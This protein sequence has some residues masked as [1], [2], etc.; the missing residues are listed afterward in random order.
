M[1]LDLACLAGVRMNADVWQKTLRPAGHIV[2][3]RLEDTFFL[4]NLDSN[5][6]FEL[7]ATGT[8]IWLW[9]E[10]HGSLVGCLEHLQAKF[11]VS[12]E[13]IRTQVEPLVLE[14]LREGLLV[15][16]EEANANVEAIAVTHPSTKIGPGLWILRWEADTG[17]PSIELGEGE[18]QDAVQVFTT[19]RGNIVVFDGYLFDLPTED[20]SPNAAARRVAEAYETH[21]DQ[22]LRDLR[23]GFFTAIW[24]R[25]NDR[26]IA[27]RDGMGVHPA[28]YSWNG[29][30]LL[31]SSSVEALLTRPE[32]TSRPHVV[33]IAE[34][35]LSTTFSHHLRE[36]FYRDIQRLPSAHRLSVQRSTLLIDRYWNPLPIGFSWA[37]ED[38]LAE[39]EPA[40]RRAVKRCLDVGAQA[41]AMSGGFDS[42]GIAAVAAELRQ[43]MDPLSALSVRFPNTEINEEATQVRVARALGMPQHFRT[44]N[45]EALDEDFVA[46]ALANSAANSCPVLGLWQGL[47]ST[48]FVTA[49]DLGLRRIL[50]G[51]G[52][53]EMLVVDTKYA[54]DLFLQGDVP[55]LVEFIRAW[56]RTSPFSGLEV[57]HF[58][59]WQAA[60]KPTLIAKARQLAGPTG[61]KIYHA[62]RNRFHSLPIPV[63]PQLVEE[64][65]DRARKSAS[66]ELGPG[67]GRYVEAMR[68]LPQMPLLSME[69]EQGREWAGRFGVRILY[70]FFDQ[71]FVDLA[72][73]VHPRHLYQGGRMKGPLRELVMKKLPSVM[74]PVRK[75]DFTV[76][77]R[78][79]LRRFGR[80]SWS[81]LH[82]AT[83]LSELGIVDPAAT[84]EVMEHFFSGRSERW[85]PVWQ[86]LSTEAWLAARIART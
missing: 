13:E 47:Y 73:R 77:G 38:E 72:L 57:A 40:L 84:D 65:Q 24:D 48:L 15:G 83:R 2:G 4:L 80:N 36:T 49:K 54:H 37:K 32:V 76:L 51:T 30:V 60:I 69:L 74:M 79:V 61:A 26:V 63:R 34:F 81:R 7:N 62:V 56:Q 43:G 18:A 17:V 67:E 35:L 52:G 3:R 75:V 20:R 8:E 12:A 10:E 22:F 31:L 86:L 64:I 16:P 78:D 25:Q 42:V 44:V 14:L 55:G 45:P 5:S 58:I 39:F 33:R 70:P 59:L 27:A 85:V 9:I 68:D 66:I 82:G 21:G 41:V 46:S 19:A 28:Y 50:F 1:A 71:D 29:R 23:G 6:V 11:D 53:D